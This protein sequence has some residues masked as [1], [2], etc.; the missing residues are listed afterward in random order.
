MY[1]LLISICILALI[2]STKVTAKNFDVCRDLIVDQVTEMAFGPHGI[3]Y[4]GK[5]ICYR[6]EEKTIL[7]YER[8]FENGVPLV[9][10]SVTTKTEIN[11]HLSVTTKQVQNIKALISAIRPG[12][13][14]VNIGQ[15]KQYVAVPRKFAGT[16]KN[17]KKKIKAVN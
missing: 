13:Y 7:K 10:I 5:V 3:P 16:R 8:S 2:S 6:D 4:T 9:V 1:R 15:K 17:A 12:Q 11:L 14:H